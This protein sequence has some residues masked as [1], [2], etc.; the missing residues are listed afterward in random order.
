MINKRIFLVYLYVAVLSPLLAQ[1]QPAALE[2][3]QRILEAVRM[4]AAESRVPGGGYCLDWHYN[5]LNMVLG[6]GNFSKLPI[7]NDVGYYNQ[8]CSLFKKSPREMAAKPR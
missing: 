6:E 5:C 2:P 1:A 7:P 8:I 3:T 4:C